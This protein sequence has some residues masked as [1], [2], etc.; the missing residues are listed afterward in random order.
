MEYSHQQSMKR[1]ERGDK[2]GEEEAEPGEATNRVVK[3]ALKP[4][5]GNNQFTQRWRWRAKVLRSFGV[6]DDD[7]LDGI[8][9]GRVAQW[10]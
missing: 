10:R 3:E 2:S 1:K 7:G 5:F 4:D 9:E 6:T 8:D